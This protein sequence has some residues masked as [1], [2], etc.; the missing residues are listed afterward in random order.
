MTIPC[1]VEA[2]QNN[3]KDNSYV[4]YKTLI[5]NMAESFDYAI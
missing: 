5:C 2:K 4:C 1:W 3:C